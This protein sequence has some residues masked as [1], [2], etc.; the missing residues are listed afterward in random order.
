[1][2]KVALIVSIIE[3]EQDRSCQI[4]A[5]YILNLVLPNRIDIGKLPVTANSNLTMKVSFKKNHN[6]ATLS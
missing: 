5:F 1:V 2:W 6:I 3:H 4:F